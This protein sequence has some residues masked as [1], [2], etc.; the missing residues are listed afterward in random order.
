MKSL[1]LALALLCLTLVSAKPVK[2]RTGT[3]ADWPAWRGADRTGISHETGLMTFWPEGGPKL[4]WK[5]SGLGEGYSTPS[6]AGKLIYGM[7]N[8]NGQEWV[9]ALDRT[10]SGKQVWATP[11]GSV[12]HDG[13][14]YA[15]PRST[16][17]VDG[18]RVYTLGL[19]GDL[20]A[21]DAKN[22]NMIWRHDLKGEFGGSVG[23]WGYSESVLVDGPWVVCTPGGAQ[24][25]MLALKKD[26]G[27]P[28]WQAKVGDVA[29]YSSI[30]KIEVDGVKQY[31]QLTRQGVI[32][33]NAANGEFLW[34]YDAPANGTANASTPV[35]GG[36]DVFA[37]SGYGN[38]G[39]LVHLT[40]SGNQFEAKEVYF[41]K[42]MKSQHGGMVLVDG[43]L[44]GSDDAV[45]TCLEFKTGEVQWTDR[46]PQ[47][48]SVVCADG[49]L[50]CRGEGGKVS[51]VRA[52]PEKCELLGQFDEPER[53]GKATWPYPV[54]ADGRLYLRDQDNLFCYDV[55]GDGKP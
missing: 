12:R 23:G 33:V 26:D 15:G 45:F 11:L 4:L 18:G 53:S 43:Y 42:K 29:D 55:R 39:G 24:A 44:Y 34:R 16:P 19:A 31:V 9:F 36:A 50:F 2:P 47:K 38:G 13:Q 41:T 17:T 52:T 6:V 49:M 7:G 28:V 51:L 54:V 35:F 25:T 27:T 20:V 30:I 21:V 32:G 14:G 46:L 40:R 22:G 1:P 10:Q 8:A 48:G 3:A 37:A 5:C